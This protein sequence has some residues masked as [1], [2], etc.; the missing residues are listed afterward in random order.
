MSLSLLCWNNELSAARRPRSKTGKQEPALS[1]PQDWESAK[2]AG[3]MVRA[4][5]G[6]GG[7]REEGETK[8]ARA[9]G[10]DFAVG[11]SYLGTKRKYGRYERNK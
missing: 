8:L 11:Q 1:L 5:R 9:G 4:R 2:R 10:E 6:G 7:A 3:R